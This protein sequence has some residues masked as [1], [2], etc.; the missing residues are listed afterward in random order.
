MLFG[1][2]SDSSEGTQEG[3][4]PQTTM[5]WEEEAILPTKSPMG[6]AYRTISPSPKPE[7]SSLW[8]PSHESS[9]EI[10]PEQMSPLL[11]GNPY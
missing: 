7:T 6:Q 3:Q 5:T 2:T 4:D 1:D 9:M 8:D 11:D 10:E